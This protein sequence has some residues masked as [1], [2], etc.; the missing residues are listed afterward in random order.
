MIDVAIAN[1][2]MILNASFLLYAFIY[3]VKYFVISVD[4]SSSIVAPVESSAILTP[5]I[6]KPP[7][8]ECK[9]ETIK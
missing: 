5:T 8:I 3:I 4:N 6:N 1:N 7:M 2:L 9:V